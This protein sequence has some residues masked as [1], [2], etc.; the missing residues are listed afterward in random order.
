MHPWRLD[1]PITVPASRRLSV[2]H[3]F[4]AELELITNIANA[5]N[6]AVALVAVHKFSV[7]VPYSLPKWSSISP[8]WNNASCRVQ[9]MLRACSGPGLK[10]RAARSTSAASVAISC[11]WMRGGVRKERKVKIG[12]RTGTRRVVLLPVR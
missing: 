6:M 4:R 7:L 2:L 8:H 5:A 9:L 3:Q 10:A 12:T 1:K 11:T